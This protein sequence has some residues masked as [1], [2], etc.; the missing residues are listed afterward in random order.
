[1]PT[2]PFSPVVVTKEAIPRVPDGVEPKLRRFTELVGKFLNGLIRS[3][4]VMPDGGGGW[5][6]VSHIYVAPRRPTADDDS[7]I[8]VVKGTT[9][10]DT[11]ERRV[12]FCVDN[13]E[14]IAHWRGPF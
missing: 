13:G 14:G 2:E 10:V 11:D 9:W 7:T 12:Y 5:T 8:G 6:I 3:G 1:M 4:S